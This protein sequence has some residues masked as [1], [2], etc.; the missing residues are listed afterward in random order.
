MMTPL[1]PIRALSRGIAVLQALNRNGALTV[2]EVC[3][4]THL[5]YATV[6][7]VLFT[8][9]GDGFV[10]MELTRK[11]YRVTALVQTLAAGYRDDGRIEAAAA[12][13]L[14]RLS[15]ETGCPASFSVRVAASMVI[16]LSTHASSPLTV[17][18]LTRGHALPVLGSPSGIAL[19]A[20]L[21]SAQRRPLVRYLFDMAGER[22]ELHDI[23]ALYRDIRSTRTRGHALRHRPATPQATSSIAVPVVAGDM[24]I[25]AITLAFTTEAMTW[26]EAEQRFRPALHRAAADVATALSDPA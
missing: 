2:S 5:P 8:L 1:P 4:I 13:P 25:G 6:S 12:E 11:R 17:N 10:E 20:A 14:A 21:R 19:L 3:D 9:I 22:G 18:M 7:R 16:R 15:R 23:G 26:Q 24:A